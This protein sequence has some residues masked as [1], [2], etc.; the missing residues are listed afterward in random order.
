MHFNENELPSGNIIV[1]ISKHLVNVKDGVVYDTYNSADCYKEIY[2]NEAD[3]AVYGYWTKGEKEEKKKA[4][5]QK[6][7]IKHLQEMAVWADGEN[8]EALNMALKALERKEG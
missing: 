6:E 8:L 2:G 7:A 1:S 5:T 4:M 3:R